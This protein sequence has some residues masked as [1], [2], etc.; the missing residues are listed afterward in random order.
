MDFKASME[1]TSIST[2]SNG[3]SRHSKSENFVQN[4]S[5]FWK[6]FMFFS[7]CYGN[8]WAS[9]CVS[10]QAPFF[11]E[12]AEQKGVSSTIYG[13]IFGIYEFAILITAPIFGKLVNKPLRYIGKVSPKYL[14]NSGLFLVGSSNML[15]GLLDL[16][17]GRIDFII[18]AFAIRIVEGI[19]AAAF[20]TA[21]YT[22]MA[23]E[24][25]DKVAVYFIHSLNRNLV[26]GD[27]FYVTMDF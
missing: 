23:S 25:P 5:S 15:F 7:L 6:Y 10:L 27:A 12:K 18:L 11:P 4:R 17:N 8:F 1:W 16:V 9:A 26:N 2:Q 22:L 24:F 14:I 13:L 19:G 20:L 21:S 3:H